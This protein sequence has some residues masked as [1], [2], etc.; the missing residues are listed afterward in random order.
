M[1]VDSLTICV[2]YWL[3]VVCW[4]WVANAKLG[5]R[6]TLVHPQCLWT[7]PGSE[8]TNQLIRHKAT[9]IRPTH[10]H[11]STTYMHYFVQHAAGQAV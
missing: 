8:T 6:V 10:V 1:R 3:A 4:Y 7:G 9:S 5:F 11:V 2:D